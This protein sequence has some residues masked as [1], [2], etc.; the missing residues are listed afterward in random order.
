MS[1]GTLTSL[2][3]RGTRRVGPGLS[4]FHARVSGVQA[5][6]AA[7]LDD[8]VHRQDVRRR[9]RIDLEFLFGAP[10]RVERGDHLLFE[11]LVD[12]RLLPE[13]AVA[14]LHPLE[15]RD[16]H[17]AGVGQDAQHDQNTPPTQAFVP[18]WR[19]RPI[20]TLYADARRKL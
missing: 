9:A 11:A 17:A 4:K 16:D 20:N 14:V 18:V 6:E 15:V 12:F 7:C 13:V 1:R 10:D 19:R 5:A 3:S 8:A 2:P